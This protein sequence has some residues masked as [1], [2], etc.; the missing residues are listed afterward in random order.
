MNKGIL[1][2]AVVLCFTAFAQAQESELHGSIDVTYLSKYVWRGFDLYDD[3][4]AIQPSVD[5]D[6]FGTGFGINVTGHR[7]N[8]D[9]F[10][11]GERWDYMFY[12]GNLLWE[13]EKYQT[14]YRLAYVYYNYPDNSAYSKSSMDLQELQAMFSWPNILPVKGLVPSY[15]LVKIWPS[16]SNTTVGTRSTSG[17]TA[18]G[19]LHVFVLDYALPIQG[20]LPDIPEQ[21]LKLH[22]EVVYNDGMGPTG[23]NVDQDW[24]HAVFGV[25]TDFDLGNNLTFTPG[26]YHQI[27]FDDSVNDDEDETWATVGVRYAF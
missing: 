19:F 20:L 8:S 17:G 22:S 18:S 13:G 5:L 11:N 14:N 2:V 25:S 12:Y 3:K 6:L 24:S 21:V 26:V 16:N 7:A 23:G 4:S 1:L 15:I 9:E 27:T 10:E